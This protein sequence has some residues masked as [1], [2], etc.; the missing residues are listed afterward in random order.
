[1]SKSKQHSKSVRIAKQP[2]KLCWICLSYEL[3]LWFSAF[4]L[5]C[6]ALSNL[7]SSSN[8]LHVLAS[9]S[10]IFG[11]VLVSIQLLGSNRTTRFDNAIFRLLAAVAMHPTGG[12]ILTNEGGQ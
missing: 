5:A 12:R 8:K 11:T 7:L 3:L 1:M 10:G 9:I 2:T 4:V 6:Y